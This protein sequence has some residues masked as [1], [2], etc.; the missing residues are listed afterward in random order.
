MNFKW[1]IGLLVTGLVVGCLV[2]WGLP[3]LRGEN[4]TRSL[5][6]LEGEES[7]FSQTKR[8]LGGSSDE[9][10]T[11]L[12]PV[13]SQVDWNKI[14]DPFFTPPC[15]WSGQNPCLLSLTRSD[16]QHFIF[17]FDTVKNKE[18]AKAAYGVGMSRI[19]GK[20]DNIRQHFVTQQQ[21]SEYVSFV[22]QLEDLSLANQ[23]NPE[24]VYTSLD[25][26]VGKQRELGQPT[27]LPDLAVYVPALQSFLQEKDA[28]TQRDQSLKNLHKGVSAEGK[29][30]LYVASV[31][32]PNAQVLQKAFGEAGAIDT[33]Y[34]ERIRGVLVEAPFSVRIPQQKYEATDYYDRRLQ[35]TFA[36]CVSGQ[37]YLCSDFRVDQQGKPWEILCRESLFLNDFCEGT[38][39]DFTP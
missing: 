34:Q 22:K 13:L 29:T 25:Y 20:P 15:Y 21:A 7:I 32:Y 1:V 9:D 2:V 38:L 31:Y 10:K 3:I 17:R 18:A 14:A 33:Y 11:S 39:P 36:G 4:Q 8:A 16:D 24:L 12:P 5:S 27:T 30:L 23:L 19:V 28:I 37:A 6:L 35:T 26:L